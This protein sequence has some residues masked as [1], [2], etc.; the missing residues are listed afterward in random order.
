[1]YSSY[2]EKMETLLQP[3][4]NNFHFHLIFIEINP[5]KTCQLYL[6]KDFAS[7]D[8]A[9]KEKTSNL[10]LIQNQPEILETA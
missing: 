4:H 10:E 9:M 3:E 5:T 8:F 2:S 7:K 6:K 1:M